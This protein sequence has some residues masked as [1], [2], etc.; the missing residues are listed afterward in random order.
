MWVGQLWYRGP[1]HLVLHKPETAVFVAEAVY[2]RRHSFAALGHT[3]E[4]PRQLTAT[5]NVS[6]RPQRWRMCEQKVEVI[7]NLL[8]DSP[9]FRPGSF[10]RV[11]V[12]SGGGVTGRVRVRV[13]DRGSS[14]GSSST[15]RSTVLISTR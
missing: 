4:V 10:E 11:G 6:P 12:I 2:F 9:P 3:V 13:R 5:V 14:N 8:E 15:A 7:W 1:S